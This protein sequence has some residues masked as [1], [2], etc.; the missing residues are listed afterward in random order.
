M[1]SAKTIDKSDEYLFFK[2]GLDTDV[3]PMEYSM[4]LAPGKMVFSA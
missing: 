1:N 3:G 2:D 4:L